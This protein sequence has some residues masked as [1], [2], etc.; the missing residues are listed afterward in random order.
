MNISH[1]LPQLMRLNPMDFGKVK[2][3]SLSFLALAAITSSAYAVDYTWTGAVDGDWNNA[4]NW[5]ANGVPVDDSAGTGNND[6]LSLHATDKIIFSAT[7][8]P[9]TNIP[10]YGGVY[11]GQA[12]PGTGTKSSPALVLS[13]GGAINFTH[14]G[15]DDSFWTNLNQGGTA[16]Q[17][18]TVGDGVTGINEDVTL[19][20]TG[21]LRMNR[22]GN[23][24][25]H[26][27]V[28][29]D[30]TL[31]MN[32]NLNRWG[33]AAGRPAFVF[34]DGGT[35]TFNDKIALTG[36][37]D[38][39][40]EFLSIGGTFTAEYAA[41]GS[42]TDAFL[43]FASVN[44]ALGTKFVNSAPD[45]FFETTDNG[46]T[47]TVTVVQAPDPNYWTGTGG[48]TWDQST[49]VNFTTNAEAAALTQDTFANAIATSGRGTFADSY[50]NASTPVTPSHFNIT[51][52]TAGVSAGDIDFS[53]SSTPYTL[54]SPNAIGIT[55]TSNVSVNGGGIVTLL[56]T[57]SHTGTTTV[58]AGSTL[59]IGDGTSDG[60]IN[61]SAL[62][63]NGAVV[64]TN[65]AAV[66]QVGVVGGSGTLDKQGAG[67][68]TL[69]AAATHS[70]A[71]TITAGEL[72]LDVNSRSSSYD[73]ASGATLNLAL[74]NGNVLVT[75]PVSTTFTGTG[76]LKKTGD[77]Q[78][79]WGSQTATFNLGSGALIDVQEGIL[80]GGSNA[81]ENWTANLSDLNIASGATFN[82]VEA[83]IRVDAITG[84]GLLQTGFANN[85]AYDDGFTMGVDNG[86]GTFNGVIANANAPA[87]I[88]K[89]GTGTQTLTGLN[90]YTGNT[91]VEDGAITIADGGQLT[92]VPT[93]N[94]INNVITGTAS[95]TINLDGT[96][97]LSLGGT[98][99]TS[100]NSWLLVDDTNLTVN[101]GGTFAVNSS[102]GSFTNIS[103]LWRLDD[104]NNIW[105][106]TQSTGT[107]EVQSALY[108]NWATS[109]GLAGGDADQTADIEG[110]GTGDGLN[111]LLE[112]AHGTNPNVS[113]NAVL[114]VVDGSSFTP[115]T[116]AVALN[117]S[118]LAVT[119]RYVRRKNHVAAGLTYTPRF[120]DSTGSYVVDAS[121]PAPTVVS[122]QDGGYEVVEAPFPLFETTGKKAQAML[123]IVDVTLAP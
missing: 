6:G 121:A 82:G 40:V 33:Q 83:S 26:F 97:N 32:S 120:I 14:V 111:N 18:L 103:G 72:V 36:F 41:P 73:I 31:I 88:Y 109:Y 98:N 84:D 16:R 8:M 108:T 90:T 20:M 22:H 46:T 29:S 43:D 118:P 55:G 62:V 77:S 5:D 99:T 23:G 54:T 112:F 70:G 38:G 34:I 30:G 21:S 110:G 56:G 75:Y 102:L 113:D 119:F 80:R 51:I 24:I 74:V 44:A 35:V 17:I 94:G 25:H 115:G 104:G 9:T 101:Y 79:R 15:H 52:D 107:L 69:T 71:T 86:S 105:T 114:S 19:T 116:P 123:A 122:T 50:F 67:T 10:S 2:F 63:N 53:N 13:S 81:N 85:A 78:I 61:D 11:D 91:T 57:H 1:S 37:N 4:G 27:R 49:T 76:I 87:Q 65:A 96:L 66:S 39:F 12:N 95:G 48:S 3:A 59:N 117:F 93:A 42:T 89:E 45:T 7:T 64:F 60:T 68:L 92:M 58:D 106:F 100:G 28:N 47:F